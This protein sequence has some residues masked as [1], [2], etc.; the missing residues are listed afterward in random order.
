MKVK[1]SWLYVTLSI[2]DFADN[3]AMRTKAVG[4]ETIRS[5]SAVDPHKIVIMHLYA[6]VGRSD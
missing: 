2:V 3:L 1:S 6:D 5:L 4:M